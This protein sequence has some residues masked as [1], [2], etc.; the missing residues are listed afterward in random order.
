MRKNVVV[1]LLLCIY[2]VGCGGQQNNLNEPTSS[3]TNE[4]TSESE[5]ISENADVA[6]IS[7]EDSLL[8]F[9][10]E[11]NDN[12]ANTLEYV[13]N[14]VPSD[15]SSSHYRTEFRLSAYENAIG[16]SYL[17]GSAT[18]DIIVREDYFG[19][20]VT[21]VYMDNATIEQCADMISIASPIMNSSISDDEIQNTI[22]YITENKEANGYYYGDL[23]LLLTG[24]DENKY[25]LMLKMKN[26]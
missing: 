18:V 2:L 16:K 1:L 8:L 21:R 20:I 14:F 11:F 6:D 24:S 4:I 12:N 19:E 22:N 5:K 17:F 25:K 15:N 7:I 9:V 3:V 23:G 13:E 10:D 26:D